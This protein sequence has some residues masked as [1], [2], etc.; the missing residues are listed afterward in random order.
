MAANVNTLMDSSG[1]TSDW[2]EILNPDPQQSVDLAGWKL[3]SG[4]DSWTFPSVILGPNEFRIVFC[5][6]NGTSQKDPNGELHANFNLPKSG[7]DLSLLDPTGNVVQ[8]FS[9]YP[10]QTDDTSYGVGEQLIGTEK[11]LVSSVSPTGTT[12][13]RYFVPP[14]GNLGTAWT[15]P[16]GFDDSAWP[17]MSPA[18]TGLGYVAHPGWA[19]MVY[20]AG[21]VVNSIALAD[22]VV[23]TASNR[24]AINGETAP[25]INYKLA[26]TT[27]DHF[28]N[29]RAIPGNPTTN[30]VIQATGT[31]HVATGGYYTFGVNCDDGFRL[32]IG[33]QS[34][35]SDGTR[36]GPADN[37]LTRNLAAGDY[38]VSLL[39]YQYTSNA[40]LE[41]Y[42]SPAPSAAGYSA[43][44]QSTTWRLVGDNSSG[45]LSVV[46]A[47]LTIGTAPSPLT[48]QIRTNVQAAFPPTNNS[49]VYMRLKFDAPDLASLS[50]LTLKMKYDDGYVAWLN[51]VEVASRNVALPVAKITRS[52]ATA[53]VVLPSHGFVNGS[54][55]RIA[56]AVQPEYNG[57]FP[58][59]VLDANA[60][61]YTVSGNPTSPATGAITARQAVV[62]WNAQAVGERDS[63]LQSTTFENV[64]LSALLSSATAG[65]LT[66]AGNVLAIQV[67]NRAT[68]AQTV[69]LSRAGGTG[70]V[71]V[72]LPN[73]G[74][75]SGE[76]VRIAGAT[77]PEYN[78]DFTISTIDN[79][80]SG[81]LLNAATHVATA[82]TSL[83]HGLAVGDSVRI[84]GA[85]QPEYNGTFV[86]A[87][88]P[89]NWTFTFAVTGTPVSPATGSIT[90]T[91][92]NRFTYVAPP[93][94][95]PA[96]TI[97]ARRVDGDLFAAPELTQMQQIVA[98]G[99]GD[100][101]FSPATPLSANLI[102][103][104]DPDLTYSVHHGFFYAPFQL[105]L[106]TTLPGASIYYTTDC[107]L[108]SPTTGKLYTGPINVT[109]S[110][111]V[112][113]VSVL[114]GVSGVVETE[115]YV[116]P[117]AV[118]GQPVNPA[119]GP[120][121][122]V[123]SITLSGT[124]ARVTLPN[125]G[126]S[127]S[128]SV[129]IAGATQTQYN[130][131]FVIT[132]VDANT[133]TYTVSGTPASPATGAITAQLGFPATWNGTSADYAMDPTI[134]NNAAYKNGL[135]QD[136]LAIPSMSI[137]T[138]PDVMF[139]P[140][141][142]YSNP[143]THS[144][145]VPGSLEYFDPATGENFQL[146]AGVSMQG[147]VGRVATFKQHSFRLQFDTIYGPSSLNFPLFGAD[148]ADKFDGFTLR[149]NFND[150]WTWGQSQAQF[151]RDEFA[152]QAKLAMGQMASHGKFVHLYVNGL[153]WGMYNPV[154]RPDQ[155][156]SSAYESPNAVWDAAHDMG[157]VKG[158]DMTMY[159]KLQNFDFA[160]DAANQ[161]RSA[162]QNIQGLPRAATSIISAGATATVTLPGHL[163]A[164]GD[165]I[166]IEG[167]QQAVY[168]GVFTITKVDADKFTYTLP[169]APGGPAVP[170]VDKTLTARARC[171]VDM[172]DYVDYLV[173]EF[174]IGNTD[175][176]GHNWYMGRPQDSPGTLDSTGF[177]FFPWDSEM[178]MGGGWNNNNPNTDSTGI[179][180][181]EPIA[182]TYQA[183]RNCPEFKMLFADRAQRVLFNNGVL[184]PSATVARYRALADLVWP[185]IITES[186]RWGDTGGT[187]YTPAT[188]ATERD[189]M[190]NNWFPVRTGIYIQQLR[191]A[192]LFPSFDAPAFSVNSTAQ[193]GGGVALNSRLTL[194]K[195]AN[196]PAGS[197]IYYSLDGTD[198]RLPDGA[199]NPS[200]SVL[201]YTAGTQIP[202]D[203]T[204]RVVAR[205]F[206]PS[207]NTWAN[208][209]SALADATYYINV[210]PYLRVTE[211]MYNPAPASAAEKAAGF[212]DGDFEFV[213]IKNISTTLTLPL[214]DVNFSNGI[215]FKFPA[216]STIAPLQDLVV[217]SNLDAFHMRYPDVGN[218]L[219]AGQYGKQL[220]N[221]G[222][223]VELD[224]P[225]GS[226]IQQFTFSNTWYPQ[227]DGGGFS[228]VVRNPLQATSVTAAPDGS[229]WQAS[230]GPNGSPGADEGAILPGSV[231]INEV[232]A[233]TDPPLID[234]VELYNTTS[235][236][237]DLS[238]WFLSDDPANLTKYQMPAGTTIADHGYRVFTAA[239]LGF[240]L[241]EHGDSV[242]LSS[243]FQGA[244]GGYRDY[245]IFG[246]SP[247]GR[248]GLDL[249][250]WI[251]STGDVDFTL[252]SSQTLGSANSAPFVGPLVINE[253][254][255]NPAPA[256]DA[257]IA[258]GYNPN[259]AGASSS[260]FEFF[261]I[262]NR[263][264]SP[265]PLKADVSGIEANNYYF[266]GGIGFTFGWCQDH[267]GATYSGGV[268]ARNTTTEV[269]TLEPGA[270]AAWRLDNMAGGSYDVYAHYT[271]TDGH[272]RLRTLDDAAQYRIQSGSNSVTKTINQGDTVT[273][274]PD[275][276]GIVSVFLGSYLVGANGAI[277]VTLTR[278]DTGPDNWTIADSLDIRITGRTTPGT[279]VGSPV[280]H[281]P[282][283]DNPNRIETLAPGAYAV[284][285][286][287]LAAFNIRYHNQDGHIPVLG[288]YTGRLS[289][290][291]DKVKVYRSE[292]EWDVQAAAYYDF[293]HVHY[294]DGRL[295]P[296]P[297]EPDGAGPGLN[298]LNVGLYGSEQSNWGAGN[299]LGTPG[300]ANLALD[301]LPPTVP[302]GLAAHV[303]PSP[304]ASITLT[305]DPAVAAAS[306]VDHYLVYRNG[307]LIGTVP[308]TP[309][310]SFTDT[311]L[312]TS[313][314]YAYQVSAVNRDQYASPVSAAV[315]A[316]IAAVVSYDAATSLQLNVNFSEP[317][318]PGGT[319][320][321]AGLTVE[322]A[323]VSTDNLSATVTL[324]A[325]TPLVSGNVYTL[326]VSNV[327]T[328]SGNTLPAS[329]QFTFTYQPYGTNQILYEYWTGINATSIDNLRNNPNYP[330]N[331]TG[332]AYQITFDAPASSSTNYGSLIRGY[333]CPPKSGNYSFWIAAD[334]IGELWLSTDETPGNKVK[335]ASVPN[336]TGAKEWGKYPQQ[337]SN[338]VWLGAGRKYYV[339]A[340]A[341]TGTSGTG[342]L[343][344]AWQKPGETFNVASGKPILS[345]MLIPY[346]IVP[347]SV[348]AINLVNS[349]TNN[350][351][352]VQFTVT[353]SEP[354]IGVVPADFA[355]RLG[356]TAATSIL[357]SG[358]GTNYTVTV[359][360]VTGN[361]T[362]GLDLVD[363]GSITDLTGNHLSPATFTGP[364]YTID[365]TPPVA[366]SI[367]RSGTNP[368]NTGTLRWAV[369]LSKAV[370][371]VDVADFRLAPT[372]SI[373]GSI[374]QV[375]GSGTSYTVTATVTGAGT[376]GL[377]LAD[378]NSIV[379]AA[380]NAL[381]G[382]G[383]T[384]PY[385]IG[386]VYTVDTT[387][388]PLMYWLKPI[389]GGT[390]DYSISGSYTGGDQDPD[391]AYLVSVRS[392]PAGSATI[393]FELYASI[394]GRD[395]SATND[396]LIG[397]L[398]DV[399][400]RPG[401]SALVGEPSPL[402]LRA[403]PF[404]AASSSV[405]QVNG[406]IDG[407]G[408]RDLGGAVSVGGTF[409][410]TNSAWV[411]PFSTGAAGTSVNA[412]GWTDI[413]VGTINYTFNAAGGAAPGQWAQLWT[414]AVTFTG[415]SAGSNYA[416][417]WKED[418]GTTKREND[419]SKIGSGPAVTVAVTSSVSVGNASRQEGN[420]GTTDFVFP[421]SLSQACAQPVQVAV[422]T[423]N[424]SAT[425]TDNDYQPLHDVLTFAPGETTK[426][427]TV[428]VNGDAKVEAD[429]TF[430]VALSNPLYNGASA[431]SISLA[432]SANVGTGTI[433]NDDTT[434]ISIAPLNA[435]Q[436][437]GSSGLTPFTFTV[438]LSLP[439]DVV[440]TVQVDT[441]DGTATVADNDYQALHQ[442]LTFAPAQTSQVVTVN[443]VGDT[444]AKPDRTFTVNL[445]NPTGPGALL[446][447]VTTAT[448]TIRNDVQ[449]TT[450]SIAPMEADHPRA[451]SGSTAFT[452]RVS[453]SGPTGSAVAVQ[454]DTADGTALA[455]NNDYQ[456]L[457]ETVTFDPGEIS[458]T[459]TVNVPGQMLLE[460]DKTFSVRLSAPSGPGILLGAGTT[461]TGNIRNSHATIQLGAQGGSLL[462]VADPGGVIAHM[463][464]NGAESPTYAVDTSSLPQL[465]VLGGAGDDQLTLDFINGDPLPNQG[466]FFDGG[467]AVAGNRLVW[468]NTTQTLWIRPTE[469]GTEL[470]T[471]AT[472]P[473]TVSNVATYS[474]QLAADVAHDEQVVID[475]A[476]V[477]ID[478]ND[479]IS[480][481]T[482]VSVI[483]GGILDL[484]GKDLTVAS[485]MSLGGSIVNGT[486]NADSHVLRQSASIAANLGGNGALEKG[487]G[488]TM[489]LTGNN[490]YRG[491]TVVT[492]GTLQIGNGA[493]V[494][495]GGALIIGAGAS[496][497][498][499]PNLILT[500]WG[501][502]GAA[503][504]VA[505]V[506]SPLGDPAPS[507]PAIQP[508]V[509]SSAAV[510]VAAPASIGEET[511]TSA[512]LGDDR[513][514]API[515][516]T[517]CLPSSSTDLGLAQT[518][519]SANRATTNG[520]PAAAIVAAVGESAPAG[521]LPPR[522]K[523]HATAAASLGAIRAKAH[524]A[525]LL[526]RG[527]SS[528]A[529]ELAWLC[530]SPS[531]GN[532]PH[533][534]RHKVSDE[535][536]AAALLASDR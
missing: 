258:A 119:A 41:L 88:V 481:T 299:Y 20:E 412:N 383:T 190:L 327:A 111:V 163:F 343:S 127:S 469:G 354:V 123:S 338:P 525:V 211:V 282:W 337:A 181:G 421:V 43:W 409:P 1:N 183:L 532:R 523:T 16:A 47:G 29:D 144:W 350:G 334:T 438:S 320:T 430:S 451:D 269:W 266:G 146:N 60:F 423:A 326:A 200:A 395:G 475:G 504:S 261:E 486:I 62:P 302:T 38:P 336:A 521:R 61:T 67:M 533:A 305:W 235:Q 2:I 106:T 276:N 164:T 122:T 77:Q 365:T 342:N 534:A 124:T 125:H 240:D 267:A 257:E 483:N 277:S 265:V 27:G 385:F 23:T 369:V 274:R 120:L 301:A 414:K 251:T 289:N 140:A 133:F 316:G 384:D 87:S 488:G 222:E 91:D 149:S 270:T 250:R 403:P 14:N 509:E 271:V 357:V 184:T 332:T 428:R 182:R 113:A 69:G 323:A 351:G 372:G 468:K 79:A 202:L 519:L 382:P 373:A 187:L 419:G 64:D 346:D 188:W 116:F 345:T 82:T 352:S 527:I 193:F 90:A 59:T 312:Q 445:S 322:S 226:L 248:T 335:I 26:G 74:F 371:G 278:G 443:V 466:L 472:A 528:W 303:V 487:Q 22:S 45:G 11:P 10:A 237:M 191:N 355:L 89:N 470:S 300:T 459:V 317:I 229:G 225:D 143:T 425:T 53:T 245:Q 72:T 254:M 121:Q 180:D 217:V 333:A 295:P 219:I 285:V 429:E 98:T 34:F 376:A 161:Y 192:G 99:L 48:S 102:G 508:A 216:G 399:F 197:V 411:R 495:P 341:V 447:P 142:L 135:V 232:L 31:I 178:A 173:M 141:G 306:Y 167:A 408:G 159:N 129:N 166:A 18:G 28:A 162:Y 101:P 218:A 150:H 138:D 361:G 114:G 160:S 126:F 94:A 513:P 242:Y 363:N 473:V 96:G 510:S 204:T 391:H 348:Q 518:A 35:Q 238:G 480:A 374:T 287:N 402:S 84:R 239:T 210:G 85:K 294:Y 401:P 128:E 234:S 246:A 105:S 256:T 227:T 93:A 179:N 378:D 467:T 404:T 81:I 243:N 296:W 479:A 19:V 387:T 252:L 435:D 368:T 463:F 49:D 147:N 340:L 319:Y 156:F 400:N 524:D 478:G 104:W 389:A 308:A 42:A 457:H 410:G 56:G 57:D 283:T 70:A 109:T 46:N 206:N 288:T 66:A 307:Q 517:E 358:S 514:V 100:H 25:W 375:T 208:T 505:A 493:A 290:S 275:A 390:G 168:N 380:G 215:K 366:T 186:A 526:D 381:N 498:F 284:L 241:S 155:D 315:M 360:G 97:T 37:F 464:V 434:A 151:I 324:A 40:G 103:T 223:T 44:N 279:M 512:S 392:L 51:G 171:L 477:R 455:A 452:F 328:A 359:N 489:V 386:Q 314:S 458:H 511:A 291:D 15:Q 50:S 244:V 281:S 440:T 230:A 474:L 262:Y 255:Y 379:D 415:T 454:V 145:S 436:P 199:I 406:D 492:S 529:E 448:G 249:G 213:E 185:A 131:T 176:P 330:D 260:D 516:M 83:A 224:A 71:T 68:A 4:G 394:G 449:G 397:G 499:V 297:T 137:V 21:L 462:I 196:A 169:S 139:G 63:D 331:P 484:N 507:L 491:G 304:P 117:S 353:F 309:T 52:G 134:T 424:G 92:A 220:G 259:A 377:N 450:V 207:G 398:L 75:S 522:E 367:N 130:G 329:Q 39:Y 86:I 503:A 54:T 497:V 253:V 490:T 8:Q 233:H 442:T 13:M 152:R 112:R 422:D 344:V 268:W 439:S 263:S 502:A 76:T 407:E 356:G 209:W 214:E 501:A 417:I 30:Y 339:E 433:V 247:N 33:S 427:V 3:R 437:D 310:P 65:H 413:L 55:V 80:V 364:S 313:A 446:G 174:Y 536:I 95:A 24:D 456:P 195:A 198:P 286:S 221:A 115:T 177:K 273:Y 444:A 78:G 107:S 431:P 321:V 453:L 236:A 272:G 485:V 228:L 108:P 405:G 416:Q 420:A 158:S 132:R 531:A 110:M 157:P 231:V 165:Q 212:D 530:P 496:V 12:S 118:I 476:S 482:A 535:A 136:L 370:T 189:I 73:H 9:S 292:G 461:A 7:S 32:T 520:S 17:A 311:D 154:E 325:G 175:W 432:P 264:A 36:T 5:S 418:S 194:T 58:I 465:R 441:V 201:A 148:A 318:L 203:G 170:Q 506:A 280:L 349:A 426:Y 205:V 515:T 153:Y 396:T 6:G 388:Q 393:K 347:P 500:F 298:R 172:T 362:L 460:N 494:P 471:N 293:D